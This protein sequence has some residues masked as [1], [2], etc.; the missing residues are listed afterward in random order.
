MR[1]W[2]ITAVVA[3]AVAF[4]AVTAF[5]ALAPKA[6]AAAD[7]HS[8]A[9]SGPGTDPTVVT[10]EKETELKL[11]FPLVMCVEMLDD[12]QASWGNG[13]PWENSTFFF[14]TYRNQYLFPS[15]TV[16][17]VARIALTIESIHTG[18]PRSPAPRRTS[19]A[20]SATVTPRRSSSR[21]RP[22][23]AWYRPLP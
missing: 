23:T 9:N 14:S 1:S 16:D 5:A 17:D 20:T 8:S 15:S 2:R 13:F 7:M 4:T 3:L 21:R 18:R 19:T 6:P 12:T 11:I 22:S 10:C